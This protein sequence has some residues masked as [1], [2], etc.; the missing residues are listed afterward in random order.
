[1]F[2]TSGDK[3]TWRA[4]R[5]ITETRHRDN[6]KQ[7][8]RRVPFCVAGSGPPGLLSSPRLGGPS[9]VSSPSTAAGNA[10]SCRETYQT[11]QSRPGGIG[12]AEE[13]RAPTLRSF[14]A[15]LASSGLGMAPECSRLLPKLLLPSTHVLSRLRKDHRSER[16]DHPVEIQKQPGHAIWTYIPNP[17]PRPCPRS[18]L[19]GV[20]SG[21]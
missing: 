15:P 3:M 13:P 7:P 19:G 9:A 16:T 10:S 12:A 21:T 5:M 20:S 17:I 18:S 2:P 8:R 6:D 1:M 4:R 14:D 11:A